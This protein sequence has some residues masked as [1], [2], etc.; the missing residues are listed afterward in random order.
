[1]RSSPSGRST[2]RPLTGSRV[3]ARQAAAVLAAAFDTDPVYG[4]VVP[5]PQR[6]ARALRALFA[7][8]IADARRC[9]AVDVAVDGRELVGVAVWLPPGR[10]PLDAKRKALAI[11]GILRLL[12]AAQASF[13]RIARLGAAVEALH[14]VE[15][16]WYL[17]VLGVHPDAARRGFGGALLHRGLVRADRRGS[18]VRLDTAVP[19]AVALYRRAGFVT[20]RDGIQLV[21]AAPTHQV[22]RRPAQDRSKFVA[23][24]EEKDGA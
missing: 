22:M 12:A 17:Q 19:A 20:L 7:L 6:R 24:D 3:E 15:R 4:C 23:L 5:D 18:P 21:D 1:M 11:P 14:R 13:G 8:A 9:G 10:F 2:V 16:A